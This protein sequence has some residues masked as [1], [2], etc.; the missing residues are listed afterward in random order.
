MQKFDTILVAIGILLVV[1]VV[2]RLVSILA[3]IV[4]SILAISLTGYALFAMGVGR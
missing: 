4:V 2:A 3:I 1:S